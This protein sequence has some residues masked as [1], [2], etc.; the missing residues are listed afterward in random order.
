MGKAIKGA[1][2]SADE[3]NESLQVLAD[4][5]RIT[6]QSKTT[7]YRDSEGRVRRESPNEI[8]ILDPVA[9]VSYTL[10]AE[11]KTAIQTPMG[12][13]TMNG[14]KVFLDTPINDQPD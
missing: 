2:Y 4:G 6:H 13:V 9:G 8:T 3:V 10:R 1:P 11:T 7:V 5:T 12:K 14:G